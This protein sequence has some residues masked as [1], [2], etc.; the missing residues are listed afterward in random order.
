MLRTCGDYVEDKLILAQRS[1]NF[2]STSSPTNTSVPAPG[3]LYST[4]GKGSEG[5]IGRTAYC[6]VKSVEGSRSSHCKSTKWTGPTTKRNRTC[7]GPEINPCMWFGENCSCC[8]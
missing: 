3:E 2:L 8:R 6:V 4:K 7:T 5:N 1:I